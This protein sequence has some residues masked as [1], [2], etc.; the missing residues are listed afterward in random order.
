MGW[1]AAGMVDILKYLA[2]NH[3]QYNSMLTMLVN[4]A[5]GIK[6]AQDPTTGL[7]YQVTDKGSQ[8]DD[9]LETSGSGLFIYA[10]KTA[11]DCGFIDK[12]YLAVA[13]KGWT[14]LKNKFT[15]DSQGMPVINDFVGAM[16]ASASYALYVAAPL[17]ACPPSTAPHGYCAALYAASAMELQVVPKYRITIS[18]VGQGSVVNP[19]GEMFLDS[20]SAV[21]LTAAPAIGYHCQWGGD[22]SG[23]SL[24]AAISMNAEKNITATFTQGSSIRNNPGLM[25]DEKGFFSFSR[26]GASISFAL[27]SAHEIGLS[28]YN[29]DGCKVREY[30]NGVFQPGNNTIDLK[31]TG[32]PAGTYFIKIV[33]EG[34]IN[35]SM[36][37][38][39]E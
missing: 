4:I 12:S 25:N 37:T 35:T 2:K 30:S 8:S 32:I 34:I 36:M 16:S 39:F 23:T 29:C 22:A 9:Y 5:E 24:T 13:Q 17:V 21:T 18:I 14:G 11:V 15:L 7:W 1:Y 28:I 3:P 27:A 26:H 31:M 38:L 6:N 19:T 10:L 33:H 20:G